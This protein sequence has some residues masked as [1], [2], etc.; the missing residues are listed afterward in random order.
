MRY[1]LSIGA[2]FVSIV[3]ACADT[4]I[5]PS[6]PYAH[7]PNAGW[8]NARGDAS[9]GA[10][11]GEYICSGYI[12]GANVGWINLGTGAPVNGVHYQNDSVSDFGVNHDGLGN[13]RGYAYGANI[14]WINFENRGHPQIDLKTG[15]LNGHAW[16]A[17]CGWI[18]LSNA[19]AHV[20][21]DTLRPGADSD[22]DGITDAWELSY[23]NSLVALTASSDTDDDGVSDRDEHGADTNPLDPND[24][25]RITDYNVVFP[26]GSDTD[27]LTWSSK[28]TRCYVV[29]SATGLE[30]IPGWTDATSLIWPDPG[31]ETTRLVPFA[32]PS[33]KRF[34]QVQALK[35]LAP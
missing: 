25:L 18:S 21:T 5:S 31:L 30:A 1:S 32:V 34:F 17:N 22:G 8:L 19:L 14:G 35:P 15:R 3:V 28:A 6:H 29:K 33:L 7:S 2:L 16:S 9:Q 26:G 11:L 24:L 13:L 10:V 23:T 4:T 20:Q 27:S 12:W